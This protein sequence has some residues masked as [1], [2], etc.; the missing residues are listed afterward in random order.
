MINKLE[1]KIKKTE[2]MDIHNI[3]PKVADAY[4]LPFSNDSLDLVYMVAV[5]QEIPDKR[6][7]LN[8]VYRVLK[9]NGILSVSEFL[10]D[11]DYPFRNTTK[12]MCEKAGFGLKDCNGNLFNYTLQFEKARATIFLI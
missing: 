6:R 5:L 2:N 11:P 3:I 7:A 10:P 8:E 1:N 4:E 12:K 9:S